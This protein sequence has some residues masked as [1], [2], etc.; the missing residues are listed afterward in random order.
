V[1]PELRNDVGLDNVVN[2]NDSR[3]V[4]RV[5]FVLSVSAEIQGDFFIL[6]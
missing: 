1:K 6:D 4:Y 3:H 5:K 2:D